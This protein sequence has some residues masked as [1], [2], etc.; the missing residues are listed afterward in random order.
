MQEYRRA[1]FYQ[2]K[3]QITFNFCLVRMTEVNVTKIYWM[4]V[5]QWI[6]IFQ[7]KLKHAQVS[8]H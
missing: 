8:M 3:S 2:T 5:N 6:T 1:K 4:V 7:G